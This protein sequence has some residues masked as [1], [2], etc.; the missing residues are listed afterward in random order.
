MVIF[1]LAE[2]CLWHLLPRQNLWWHL[3][4][5]QKML[6]VSFAW[7]HV[8]TFTTCV[9]ECFGMIIVEG[10]CLSSCFFVLEFK[11]GDR[12]LALT[13]VVYFGVSLQ[14]S[15]SLDGKIGIVDH[16]CGMY[17]PFCDNTAGADPGGPGPPD[18]QK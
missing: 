7:W 4:P 17:L 18:H 12:A 13:P 14:Y 3:L 11:V 8:V 9:C 10:R 6:S 2:G 15:V 16:Y 1:W 5:R